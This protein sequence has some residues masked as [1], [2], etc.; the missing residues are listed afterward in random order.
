M[1]ALGC[2]LA[3]VVVRKHFV[4]GLRCISMQLSRGW[5][6]ARGCALVT[7]RLGRRRRR[8]ALL[9]SSLDLKI[10]AHLAAESTLKVPLLVTVVGLPYPLL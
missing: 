3:T 6:S 4:V 7:L 8:E 9:F 5:V 2:K 1:F 10:F